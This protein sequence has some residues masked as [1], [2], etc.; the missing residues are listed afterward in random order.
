MSGR[1]TTVAGTGSSHCP[2]PGAEVGQT[3]GIKKQ[4]SVHSLRHTCATRAID[5]GRTVP[6]L[7]WILGYRKVET[8]YTLVHLARTT[9]TQRTEQTAL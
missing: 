8:A 1:M 7:K 5:M 6:E 2:I 9:R 4:I 3:G